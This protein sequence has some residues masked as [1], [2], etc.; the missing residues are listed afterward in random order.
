M[1][2]PQFHS[3]NGAYKLVVQIFV[4]IDS[5]I[6]VYA[7]TLKK[8]TFYQIYTHLSIKMLI[9]LQVPYIVR[10]ALSHHQITPYVI[11]GTI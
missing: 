6:C 5:Y 8:H 7:F 11:R 1:Y 3:R 2:V 10:E 9:F 4:Y